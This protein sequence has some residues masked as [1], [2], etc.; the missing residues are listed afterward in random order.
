MAY[1]AAYA[2]TLPRLAWLRLNPASET[3]FRDHWVRGLARLVQGWPEARFLALADWLVAD[4][5]KPRYR[6]DV[7]AL[8]QGH[9]QQGHPIVLVSTMFPPVLDRV[10]ALVGADATIGTRYEVRDGILTGHILGESCVGPRK[11]TLAKAYIS[12]LYP[13]ISLIDCA[14]YADSY[15]DVPL[16]EGA[17]QAVAVYPEPELEAVAVQRGWR[18]FPGKEKPLYDD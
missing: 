2:A 17:G 15:S 5:L 6:Q 4:Y 9:R 1:S 14:A 10:A 8:L 12:Q 11:L 13:N 7:I 18:V 3:A 16:L